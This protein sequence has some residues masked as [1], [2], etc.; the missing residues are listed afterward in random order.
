VEVEELIEHARHQ[1]EQINR[2][3]RLEVNWD[4]DQTV[5]PITTDPI[6]L[7]EILQNLIAN[8][9]KFTPRGRIDVQVRNLHD[10]DLVQFSVADTGIGIES[11]DVRRIFQEF[12]QIKEAHTG[13]FDGVGLGL[14]IVKKYLDLLDGEIRVESEPGHGSIF[15]F[16]IPRSLRRHAA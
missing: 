11:E 14:S 10:R 15:T 13:Q 8:A 9:C 3:G 4:V 12:E 7:E 1:V 5:P 6:K 16:T 2:D